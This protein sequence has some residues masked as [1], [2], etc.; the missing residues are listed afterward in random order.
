MGWLQISLKAN[1]GGAGAS[2]ADVITPTCVDGKVV[3]VQ[4]DFHAG[5]AAGI[6]LTVKTQGNHAPSYNI[7][8]NTGNTNFAKSPTVPLYDQTGAAVTYDGT[9]AIRMP[10]PVDDHIE[11]TIASAN[12]NDLVDVYLLIE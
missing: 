1:A 8:T 3:L 11:V 7:V 6:V 12:S 5:G 4:A 9:R 2:T 10:V